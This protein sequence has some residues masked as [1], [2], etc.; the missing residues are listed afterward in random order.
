MVPV[1]GTRTRAANPARSAN[2]P[3]AWR[4][5]PTEASTGKPTRPANGTATS[6]PRKL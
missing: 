6:P 3:L 4:T 5:G 2:G 1:L